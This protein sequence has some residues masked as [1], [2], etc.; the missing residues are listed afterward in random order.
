M[1][2][3]VFFIVRG[4]LLAS[5]IILWC[6]LLP[7]TAQFPFRPF[8]HTLSPLFRCR[9]TGRV[10]CGRAT[11]RDV[12]LNGRY[13]R[14]LAKAKKIQSRYSRKRKG[15]GQSL[16]Y[17]RR[18]MYTLF[19]DNC[20]ITTKTASE[21]AILVTNARE[22][23]TKK[24]DNCLNCFVPRHVLL[25]YW[26]NMGKLI[27]TNTIAIH[28]GNILLDNLFRNRQRGSYEQWRTLAGRTMV[29]SDSRVVSNW[30]DARDWRVNK[31]QRISIESFRN[32]LKTFGISWIENLLYNEFL[33]N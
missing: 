23:R 32:L 8:S 33:S 3:V 30:C 10:E 1:V 24:V 19:Y 14:T 15:V 6:N 12:L 20:W 31:S 2:L 4:F 7:A 21:D 28:R 16:S 11:V 27:S 18:I 17:C 29:V 25:I 26:S 22:V 9:G 13:D 5:L